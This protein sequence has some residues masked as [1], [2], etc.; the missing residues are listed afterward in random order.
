MAAQGLNVCHWH[1]T[2]DQGWRI[3]LPGMPEL[4]RFGAPGDDYPVTHARHH[5]RHHAS[6]RIVSDYGTAQKPKFNI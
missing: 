2:D 6:L 1:L 4:V 3:D 5:A